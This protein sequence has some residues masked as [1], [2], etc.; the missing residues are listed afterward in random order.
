MQCTYNGYTSNYTYGADGLR[1][2][3]VVTHSGLPTVTTDYVLDGQSVARDVVVEDSTTTTKTYIPGISGPLGYIKHVEGETDV[4]CWY[5]YDGLGS[6]VAEVGEPVNNDPVKVTRKYD[7]YGGVRTGGTGIATTNHGFV[8]SLGHT[9]EAETGLIYMGA[10]Y[11]DPVTGRFISEDSAKDGT[12]WYAY[13]GNNPVNLVD[14][15]GC[16]MMSGQMLAIASFACLF[17]YVITIV[18]IFI[19]MFIGE[20]DPFP[21]GR[22]QLKDYGKPYLPGDWYRPK[23]LT[24]PGKSSG[25]KG[26]G[27]AI[28]FILN[29]EALIAEELMCE[30]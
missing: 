10:R 25:L 2:R 12:N 4:V 1:R 7:V 3:S 20:D 5:L 9:S 13:C 28:Q 17:A 15:S 22:G 26:L 19:Y 14:P 16:G 23:R 21:P 11:M 30:Q 24:F 29:V 27:D 18:T 8:G 6:V